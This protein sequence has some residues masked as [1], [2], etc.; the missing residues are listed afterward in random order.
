MASWLPETLFEIVGQGQAPSK[1]YYQLLVTQT[2]ASASR[3]FLSLLTPFPARPGPAMRPAPGKQPPWPAGS[4]ASQLTARSPLVTSAPRPESRF[5]ARGRLVPGEPSLPSPSPN[6]DRFP[7]YLLDSYPLRSLRAPEKNRRP[8][9]RAASP[10]RGKEG[11]KDSAK[12][13]KEEPAGGERDGLF[14]EPSNK[15]VVN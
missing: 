3:G 1:D 14:Q 13:P 9:L 4:A 2:Q 11:K 6:A 12:C 15:S 5:S 10:Q 8:C 7:S